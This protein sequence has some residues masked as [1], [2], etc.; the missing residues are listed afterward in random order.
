MDT[1]KELKEMIDEAADSLYV[2]ARYE[3]AK[4]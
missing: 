1:M 3:F 4:E 2:K